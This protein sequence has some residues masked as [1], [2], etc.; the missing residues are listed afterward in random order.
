MPALHRQLTPQRRG[1]V[2]AALRAAY[3]KAAHDGISGHLLDSLHGHGAVPARQQLDALVQRV[4]P[5]L[6]ALGEYDRVTEE[7]DRVASQGN[8]AMRQ[9]KV[10]QRRGDMM[11][12]IDEAAAATC[13]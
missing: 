3:W 2:P 10:W 7:L 12:V 4:R 11:D 5:A 8:G 6:D 1:Q 13:G 9:R